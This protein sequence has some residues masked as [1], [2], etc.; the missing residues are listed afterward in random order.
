MNQFLKGILPKSP[1]AY[2]VYGED[3]LI[4][5]GSSKHSLQQRL[6]SH[7]YA[8]LENGQ[9]STRWGVFERIDIK[10]RPCKDKDEAL[11]REA[12]LIFKLRPPFNEAMPVARIKS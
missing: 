3:S 12:R 8:Q 5:L 10:Y 4:Y 6:N 11:R 7:L 1:G 2:A 9:V